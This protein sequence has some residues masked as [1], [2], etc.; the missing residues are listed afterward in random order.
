VNEEEVSYELFKAAEAD[1]TLTVLSWQA[2]N[3]KGYFTAD[4]K[5]R[6]PSGERMEPDLI[7][8]DTETVWAIEVKGLHSE[9]LLDETK[10][11]RLE[12]E[13][14]SSEVLE[15]VSLRAGV[16]VTGHTLITGVA[17][18]EDD[19]AS[20][21]QCEPSLVHI[22]WT[23]HREEAATLGLRALLSHLASE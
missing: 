23:L 22:C 4:V 8:A 15:Q 2:V 18:D 10:L 13:M 12:Q 14:S 21:E 7:V 17:F 11:R 20:S 6:L 9:A 1:S 3:G 16:E 5:L 19:L